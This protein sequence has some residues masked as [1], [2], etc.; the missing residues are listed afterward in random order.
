MP[1]V[2]SKLA[3]E[4]WRLWFV[5]YTKRILKNYGVYKPWIQKSIFIFFL[6]RAVLSMRN[7]M[8]AFKKSQPIKKNKKAEVNMTFFK[9]FFKIL[10]IVMPG[11]R[12]KEFW[13]LMVHSGFL[14][15]TKVDD[16]RMTNKLVFRT[17]LSVY[18]ASLDGRIV[19]ALVRGQAREF[20]L[21]IGWWMTV[22]IPAT[23]TNSMVSVSLLIHWTELSF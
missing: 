10:K 18:I 14:G 1:T 2:F 11:L 4:E 23:Y 17:V 6:I 22:A 13:L 16:I 7:L 12:S 5:P 9:Q 3:F 21:G 15:K 8:K 19:S 20:M